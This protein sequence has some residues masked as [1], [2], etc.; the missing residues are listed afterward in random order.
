MLVFSILVLV[1]IETAWK[2]RYCQK[3]WLST[4][5][6]NVSWVS[7]SET[8]IWRIKEGH[9][10]LKFS[11]QFYTRVDERQNY[12]KAFLSPNV[13]NLAIMKITDSIGWLGLSPNCKPPNETQDARILLVK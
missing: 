9:L 13:S 7:D 8:Y 1:I 5:S 12:L 11:M 4:T 6:D 10:E 2:Y 3:C